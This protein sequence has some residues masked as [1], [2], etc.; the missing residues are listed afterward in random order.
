MKKLFLI[1]LLTLL[2]SGCI[3]PSSNKST[4]DSHINHQNDVLKI[5]ISDF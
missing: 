1:I 3:V 2:I 4:H 5:K